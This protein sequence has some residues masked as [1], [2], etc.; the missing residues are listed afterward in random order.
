MGPF[1]ADG[2]VKVI[3]VRR[4]QGMVQ[5][6]V[7]WVTCRRKIGIST[8]RGTN[9]TCGWSWWSIHPALVFAGKI[10]RD[11]FKL[12]QRQRQPVARRR[13]ATGGVIH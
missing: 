9:V 2:R 4:R 5:R 7:A 3:K 11:N 6:A 13:P 10:R 1:A 8:V 12:L